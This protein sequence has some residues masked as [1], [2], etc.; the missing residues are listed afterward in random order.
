M[1]DGIA[2]NN[3]PKPDTNTAS[4]EKHRPEYIVQPPKLDTPLPTDL[5]IVMHTIMYDMNNIRTF[6]PI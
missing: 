5:I 3:I 4:L 6:S 2:M 1:P